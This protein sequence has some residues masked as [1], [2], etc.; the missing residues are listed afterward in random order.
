MKNYV[1]PI[2]QKVS[3]GNAVSIT[4]YNL[5]VKEAKA[6]EIINIE[7]DTTATSYAETKKIKSTATIAGTPTIET[8]DSQG[9]VQ[10]STSSWETINAGGG[11]EIRTITTTT[12]NYRTTTTTPCTIVRTTL[13]N[14]K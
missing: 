14:V 10:S 12:P 4:E 5:V 1:K 2:I 6:Q 13:L 9:E 7:K 8:S 11:D 3:N